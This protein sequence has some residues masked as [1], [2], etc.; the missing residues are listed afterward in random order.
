VRKRLKR[1]IKRYAL[2]WFVI[3]VIGY[4]LMIPLTIWLFPATT[5]S[6][7]IY[8]LLLGFTSSVASLADVLPEEDEDVEPVD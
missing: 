8:I 7:S 6:L 1:F 2:H 5:L 3:T 4:L